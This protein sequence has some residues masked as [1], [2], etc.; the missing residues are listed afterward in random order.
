M[1]TVECGWWWAGLTFIRISSH[2]GST[3]SPTA[4]ALLTGYRQVFPSVTPD[5][6]THYSFSFTVKAFW[7]KWSWF[8]HTGLLLPNCGVID[9]KI[10]L[11]VCVTWGLKQTSQSVTDFHCFL[12]LCACILPRPPLATVKIFVLGK[13]VRPNWRR[14]CQSFEPCG[15]NQKCSQF[16]VEAFNNVDCNLSIKVS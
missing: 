4:N 12:H 7:S 14:S 15:E 13:E 2:S 3:H 11:K 16:Q 8:W 5:N 1:C 10:W 9:K 6:C